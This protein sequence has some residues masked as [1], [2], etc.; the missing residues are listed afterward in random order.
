MCTDLWSPIWDAPKLSWAVPSRVSQV[1]SNKRPESNVRI[2]WP[3]SHFLKYFKIFLFDVP[4][5][6]ACLKTTS[7]SD[8]WR[9]KVKMPRTSQ[10]CKV[11]I[12]SWWWQFTALTLSWIPILCVFNQIPVQKM[13]TCRLQTPT[14]TWFSAPEPEGCTIL[15]TS[16]SKNEPPNHSIK[17]YS[18]Q[19]RGV[20]KTSSNTRLRKW[21]NSSYF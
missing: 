10:L 19:N 1:S 13:T 4:K 14:L 8:I 17:C 6:H 12:D 15:K 2:V 9:N 5:P 11:C 7:A 20:E 3:C 18:S 16:P 21:K